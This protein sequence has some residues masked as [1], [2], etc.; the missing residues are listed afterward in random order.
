[1]SRTRKPAVFLE[2]ANYR[3]RR[4]RDG[5]RLLPFLGIVLWAI[6]LA[7]S[8]RTQDAVMSSRGL[9]YIF[10]VWVVLIIATFVLASRMRSDSPSDPQDD[11]SS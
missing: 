4:L 8:T 9:L 6:P 7:W 3:Q 2:R 11:L 10:G 1:M 5:A